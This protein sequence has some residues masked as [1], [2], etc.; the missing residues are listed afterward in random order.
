[1]GW[2]IFTTILLALALFISAGQA[3]AQESIKDNTVRIKVGSSYGSGAYVGGRL[4]LTCYHL[5]RGE[6]TATTD[7]WFR[8]GV[9]HTGKMIKVDEEWDQALI[10]LNTKP[11]RMGIPIANENP[12]P[13][14]MVH[15]Y[16]YG[17]G[18][19]LTVT[20]GYVAKFTAPSQTASPEWFKTTGTV[21]Q[22]TSGGPVVN[23][24][25]YIIG[26]MWGSD[27]A[28]TTAL[29]TGRTRRFLLPWK[30]RLAQG[31]CRGGMCYPNQQGM[32]Q[33]PQGMPQGSTYRP[34]YPGTQV[35]HT[36]S[37]QMV[38]LPSTTLAPLPGP[39]LPDLPLPDAN[40]IQTPPSTTAPPAYQPNYG[41]AR[42][43][44]P[45]R[46]PVCVCEV[47]PQ[48]I[49][50][51]L[52][53]DEE[54]MAAVKG[55]PGQ[56]GAP[57]QDGEPGLPG[58]DAE[59]TTD[60]IAAMTA[61]IIQTLKADQEF[62]DATTGPA[63]LEG[64]QGV[65]G[66]QGPVGPAGQAGPAGPEGPA[67]P[68]GEPGQTPDLPDLPDSETGWSHLVLIAPTQ[69]EY[70][71][72]LEYDYNK[73]TTH[74]NMIRHVEPPTDRNIGPMPVLVAYSGGKPAKSWIGLRDVSQALNKIVR[75]EY[76]EFL[77]ATSD[78]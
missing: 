33:M 6:N 17:G 55:E 72:R 46:Q 48:K 36:P 10:E 28:Y 44:C 47:D 4:V 51:L 69:S 8:D 15:T 27:G 73:A 59:L 9:Q 38:P 16:G 58:Q 45:C 34:M 21:A 22:G 19:H 29:T 25:G 43:P 37:P 60:H 18:S 13:G 54:F 35:S 66:Q 65:D 41:V 52:K 7:I 23:E 40:T 24:D 77:L 5:Y 75:G 31:T 49:V 62:I 14:Q 74:Y 50:D 57:G 63:G 39:V 20:S 3:T 42:P 11:N 71:Y 30:N 76:D 78:N 12:Q 1:M 56:D 61:A 26:N 32:A 67:G 2:K 68:A 53:Q 70:W 64:L